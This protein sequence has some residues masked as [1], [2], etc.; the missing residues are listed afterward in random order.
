MPV[1]TWGDYDDG[2]TPLDPDETEG[3]IPDHI[4]TRAELNEWEAENIRAALAWASSRPL[5]MLDEQ[6]LRTLHQ[7]MFNKTWRWAGRYRTTNKSIG[8]YA[9]H[10][11][12]R[13]VRDLLANTRVQHASALPSPAALDRLAVGFHHQLVLIH[14][15]PNGNGRH[16]REATDVL[17]RRWGRPVFT[18]GAA[19]VHNGARD[20]RREYLAAL[21]AAD[22]GDF[23]PLMSFVR[24]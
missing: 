8:P 14:P 21:R 13:R 23:A 3:L 24:S 2:N 19:E 18:W 9:W 1:T 20:V 17:L 7:R 12:P 11:V 10:E 22:A 16:A 6:Q 15:W 4:V 5:D